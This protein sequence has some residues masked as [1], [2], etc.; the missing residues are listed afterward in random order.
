MEEALKLL[1]L[2]LV[3]FCLIHQLLQSWIRLGV[4]G[5]AAGGIHLA[6]KNRVL[7]VW[8]KGT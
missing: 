3:D 1:F 2:S 7:N 5:L 8:L 4:C 6:H